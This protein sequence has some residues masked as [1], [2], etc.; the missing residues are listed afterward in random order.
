MAVLRLV[1]FW[2]I[3]INLTLLWRTRKLAEHEHRV[4]VKRASSSCF[5]L[6]S[7]G[8]AMTLCRT[9]RGPAAWPLSSRGEKKFWNPTL[10]ADCEHRRRSGSRSWRVNA[11]RGRENVRWSYDGVIALFGYRAGPGYAFNSYQ[12]LTG[13]CFLT[14]CFSLEN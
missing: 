12:E 8:C 9:W 6:L 13:F 1:M 4:S 2:Q 11:D 5:I 3:N 14:A 7:T 10:S